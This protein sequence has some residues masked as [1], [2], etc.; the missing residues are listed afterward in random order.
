MILR[1]LAFGALL[2]LPAS[3][4]A[5]ETNPHRAQALRAH[6]GFLASDLLEGRDTGT[7]GFDLAA[8][9]VEAQFAAAGLQPAGVS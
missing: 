7:R 5:A 9:Y 1:V 2:G 8:A 6:T 3:A 4:H